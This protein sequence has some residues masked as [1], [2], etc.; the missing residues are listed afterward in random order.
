[1]INWNFGPQM[2]RHLVIPA[3][4]LVSCLAVACKS[5]PSGPPAIAQAY[6]GPA[7][8]PIRQD[9]SLKS[10][11]V[12]TA[13]HGDHLDVLQT[14]RRF[15]RVRTSDGVIGWV[16]S[17]QLISTEQMQALRRMAQEAAKMPV[18]GHAT[19]FEA[20]NIHS[21][22]VRTSPSFAQLPEGGAVDV[23][24]H[25]ITPRNAQPQATLP[26]VPPRPPP[27]R[28][29]KSATEKKARYGA[30]VAPPPLPDPPP[31]PPNWLQLSQSAPPEPGTVEEKKEEPPA[32]P[33]PIDDWSFVRTKDGKAGWVLARMLTM[34]IPDEVAQYAE[35]HRITSYFPL[36]DIN[37]GGQMRHH[38]LWTTSSKNGVDYDFD[39]F[40]V[41]VWSLNHHR[42]ETGFINRSV[43]GYYPVEATKGTGPRG[44]GATFSLILDDD[45]Q[46]VRK[47]YVFNGYRVSLTNTEPW[48]TN[49]QPARSA[50]TEQAKATEPSAPKAGFLDGVKKLFKR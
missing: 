30:P 9:L 10:R 43:V 12:S 15:V 41:F 44:E 28:R 27:A 33:V 35:G 23:L 5:R 37:D 24:G 36:A 49:Q 13:K 29:R 50:A 25:K 17:R 8:L 42:Y 47:T 7:T 31:P 2:L 22:P 34:S 18:Q 16:D 46:L 4:V 6:A 19:V 14:R 3:L 40:R 26:I 20:L 1:L 38:W 11:V 21:E 45:G 48:Q 32:K 39:S